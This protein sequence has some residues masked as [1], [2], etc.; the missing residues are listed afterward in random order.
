MSS[1][2][3][4]ITVAFPG[5]CSETEEKETLRATIINSTD[6]I[7]SYD[8]TGVLSLSII[9]AAT[10]NEHRHFFSITNTDN[11]VAEELRE[12]IARKAAENNSVTRLLEFAVCRRPVIDTEDS[13]A[14]FGMNKYGRHLPINQSFDRVHDDVVIEV[15]P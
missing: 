13:L 8:Q 3:S 5:S 4:N 15:L 6:F 10:Q 2:A 7:A 11:S 9:F 14:E 1:K 12:S